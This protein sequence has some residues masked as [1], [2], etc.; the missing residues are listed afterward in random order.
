MQQKINATIGALQL[1]LVCLVALDI[2]AL[3]DKQIGAVVA[4][5]SAVLIAVAAWFSPKVPVGPSE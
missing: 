3:T 2:V 1:V 5:A 4:A